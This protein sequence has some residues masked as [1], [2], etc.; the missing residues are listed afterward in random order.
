MNLQVKKE[1][2]Y[3]NYF[4][5]TLSNN[6]PE[7]LKS[8]REKAFGYFTENGFPTVQNEEWKYTNVAPLARENFGMANNAAEV[9]LDK[10]AE[11]FSKT[12]SENRV[13]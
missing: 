10:I 12:E 11:L 8:L 5:Q 2:I 1:T 6:Q 7:W 13:V 9:D 4:R 3:S